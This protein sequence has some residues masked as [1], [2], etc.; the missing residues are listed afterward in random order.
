MLNQTEVHFKEAELISS[1]LLNRFP[2]NR[3]KNIYSQAMH[4]FDLHFNVY[5]NALWN[6]MMNSKY[7][8]AYIDAGLAI[9]NPTNIVRRKIY[10]MLAIL[11]ASPDFTDYF[12]SK[13]FSSLYLINILITGVKAGMKAAAGLLFIKLIAIK[14]R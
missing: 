2:G 1:Y 10:T 8:M 12:L 11:E 9:S 3:E 6:A 13:K 4:K 14:C 7:H 5:E